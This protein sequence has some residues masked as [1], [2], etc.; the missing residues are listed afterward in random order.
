MN[1]SHDHS[2]KCLL[3]CFSPCGNRLSTKTRSVSWVETFLSDPSSEK[4][5]VESGVDGAFKS[6]LVK[7]FAIMQV[8]RI[9]KDVL[10][11]LGFLRGK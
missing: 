11:V 3:M 7:S 1:S 6:F 5:E 2:V 9:A 4:N 10:V 8:R